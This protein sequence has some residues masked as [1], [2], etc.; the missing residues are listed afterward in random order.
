MGQKMNYT[1]YMDYL[2]FLNILD[3]PPAALIVAGIIISISVLLRRVFTKFV[4]KGLK[5]LCAKNHLTVTSGIVDTF[6]KP[7]S[8]C[9]LILG[10]YVAS[11]II[12]FPPHLAH[13]MD[14]L[15]HSL[16]TFTFFWSIYRMLDS[17]GIF[18]DVLP[19]TFHA[20]ISAEMHYFFVSIFKAL[21]VFIGAMAILQSWGINVAAFLG[22][23]GLV[24]MAVALAAQETLKNLFGSLSIFMDGTFHKGDHIKIADVEGNIEKIGLRTTKIRQA[25]RALVVVPNASL[26][27]SAVVNFSRRPLR[28]IQWN[29]LLEGDTPTLKLETII[30]KIR[31][32]L[33]NY[34]KIETNPAK[35]KTLVYFDQFTDGSLNLYCEFF[36]KSPDWEYY[37][38]VKH[39]S[40]L[41]FKNLFES[42]GIKLTQ[43]GNYTFPLHQQPLKK[44][45]A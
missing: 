45:K 16:I 13:F 44:V 7:L 10:L 27:N 12:L 28:R 19:K 43:L 31:E 36:S 6:E 42:E 37:L 9:F 38:S 32:F 1:D 39:E 24:G 33:D 34:P 21:T 29:I 15:L 14:Y 22:G 40:L 26:V 5:N 25:D 4:I 8:F 3:L 35:A 41:A 23:L 2:G 11:K 20:K 18:F 30:P 17:F